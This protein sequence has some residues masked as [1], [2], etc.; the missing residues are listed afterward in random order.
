M[1]TPTRAF[2]NT[3]NHQTLEGSHRQ[4][5]SHL[6]RRGREDLRAG[7]H[8]ARVRG[9]DHAIP[10]RTHYAA[11]PRATAQALR[12]LLAVL[13]LACT[14][15]SASAAEETATRPQRKLDVW[16]VPTPHEIVDR[17]L[18]VAKV[19]TGD[20]VYDLGCGDGRMVIAAAKKYGTRGVGVDLD[21]ARIREAR[22]P[23]RSGRASSRW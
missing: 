9:E 13:L 7:A 12:L 3:K 23:M 21:P 11:R 16:Y 5:D 17:M 10:R 8:A 6:D 22:E 2:A 15:G 20:V 14:A 19:R 4:R 1:A 18:D